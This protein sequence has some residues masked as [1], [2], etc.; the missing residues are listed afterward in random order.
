MYFY[1]NLAL[2]PLI[3]RFNQKAIFVYDE[4]DKRSKYL[5]DKAIKLVETK[6]L[7]LPDDIEVSDFDAN[8]YNE[9][10]TKECPF[11]LFLNAEKI[12]DV[13]DVTSVSSPDYVKSPLIS[14]G[15]ANEKE[16]IDI[17]FPENN[18]I[19]THILNDSRN[20]D[21]IHEIISDY[22]DDYFIDYKIGSFINILRVFFQLSNAITSYDR[23]GLKLYG[24]NTKVT[25]YKNINSVTYMI[26]GHR[27]SIPIYLGKKS[28]DKF[29]EVEEYLTSSYERPNEVIGIP[30][31]QKCTD[32]FPIL[33]GVLLRIDT[34]GDRLFLDSFLSNLRV[35]NNAVYNIYFRVGFLVDMLLH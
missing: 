8:K 24:E 28:V 9:A 6:K 21:F 1:Y 10:K 4:S 33:L 20:Y 30:I 31:K 29:E 16:L 14:M 32:K 17:Q 13:I 19:M 18:Y 25:N 5:H 3:Y 11:F 22:L 15:L 34:E 12:K 7:D 35:F 26:P 23:L 27:A 2:E